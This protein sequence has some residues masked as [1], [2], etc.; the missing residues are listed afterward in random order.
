MADAR[1][2]VLFASSP[3]VDAVVA[4]V[5]RNP[6]LARALAGLGTDLAVVVEKVQKV[7]E[8]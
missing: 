4:S 2:A 5:N 3:W 7:L 1:V 8:A 6:D